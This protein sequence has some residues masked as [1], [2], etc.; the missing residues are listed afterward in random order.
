MVFEEE[1]SIKDALVVPEFPNDDHTLPHAV[2]TTALEHFGGVEFHVVPGR[3]RI[4]FKLRTRGTR[5]V[6]AAS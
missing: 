4:E 3:R 1:F 6:N 5:V 2:D